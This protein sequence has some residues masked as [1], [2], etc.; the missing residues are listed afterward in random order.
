MEQDMVTEE[1]TDT[2][3]VETG[4]EDETCLISSKP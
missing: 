1:K 2:E 4:T 3:W